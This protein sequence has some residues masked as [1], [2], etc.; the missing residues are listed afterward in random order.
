MQGSIAQP[1]QIGSAR[2]RLLPY[3]EDVDKKGGA[4][5]TWDSIFDPG[6]GKA[7]S[8]TGHW[9]HKFKLHHRYQ[10]GTPE[11]IRRHTLFIDLFSS[12]T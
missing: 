8:T 3:G 1:T 12:I 5:V 6:V 9:G 2:K 7:L 11:M 4:E 10:I